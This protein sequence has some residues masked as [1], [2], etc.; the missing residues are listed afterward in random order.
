M[1]PAP[2]KPTPTIKLLAD[3]ISNDFLLGL[4]NLTDTPSL[5]PKFSHKSVISLI[6]VTSFPTT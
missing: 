4:G 3:A 1:K 5:F 6:I 2:T